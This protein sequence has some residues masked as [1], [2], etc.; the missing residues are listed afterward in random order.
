MDQDFLPISNPVQHIS[1]DTQRETEKYLRNATRNSLK[2]EQNQI[3]RS[4]IME[5][6]EARILKF[7]NQKEEVIRNIIR[8]P[9]PRIECSYVIRG[10][11]QKI[12]C[13]PIQIRVEA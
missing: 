9:Q 1:L 13:D 7:K 8:D 12:T 10:Q 6:I 2:L 11:D 3:N 5:R 4:K